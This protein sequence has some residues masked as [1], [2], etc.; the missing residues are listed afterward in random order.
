MHGDSNSSTT[1]AFDVT[2]T[3][4]APV[5]ILGASL[6]SGLPLISFDAT[7]YSRAWI[8]SMSLL[9]RKTVYRNLLHKY[10]MFTHWIK[11]ERIPNVSKRPAA[12][13]VRANFPQ[14]LAQSLTVMEGSMFV[15]TGFFHQRTLQSKL[16]LMCAFHGSNC[17]QID[18]WWARPTMYGY[19]I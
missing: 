14:S 6:H 8:N 15:T 1:T 9:W 19:G 5:H 4:V 2:N 12:V 3:P 18:H 7:L 10:E 17:P 16:R 13:V 11:C